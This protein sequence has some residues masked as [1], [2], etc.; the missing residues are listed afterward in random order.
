[1]EKRVSARAIIIENGDEVLTMFRRKKKDDGSF[2]EYYV[3]PGGG[4]EDNETLEET[5][6]REIKEEFNVDVK[7]LGYLGSEEKE[8][9]IGHFFHVEIV[10]GVPT[11]GGEESNRNNPDNFYE[12]RRLNLD[13][14]DDVDIYAKDFIIKAKNKEY[15]GLDNVKNR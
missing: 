6:I 9:T 8:T 5:C 4:V 2:K 15:V 11:L 1:M 3:I 12:I 13:K 7:I 10:N 14:L